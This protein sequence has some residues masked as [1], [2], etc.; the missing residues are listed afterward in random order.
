[1]TNERQNAQKSMLEEA[2]GRPGVA[3]IVRAFENIKETRSIRVEEPRAKFAAGGN[4]SDAWL[5]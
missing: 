1:M 3:E 5:G 4:G 2:M